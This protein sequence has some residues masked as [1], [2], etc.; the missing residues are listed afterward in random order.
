MIGWYV[1]HHGHGHLARLQAVAAHLRTPVAGLS[2]L[3]A[4]AGWEGPWLRLERDD[5]AVA[6]DADLTALDVTCNGVLHWAPLHDDGLADRTAQVASWLAT[7]RPS[8]VVVDVSVEVSVL[9]RLAGV[10]V[11]VV[12]MPG[13]RRDRAHRLAYDLADALLAPWPAGTHDAGWPEHWRRKLWAVGGITR[14]DASAAHRDGVAPAPDGMRA[15]DADGPRR[16]LVLWGAGGTDVGA[17]QL[18]AARAVTP[19]WTWVER[20]PLNPSPDLAADLAEAD[21]VVTH[22]GQNAVADV[23]ALRRPAVVVAQQRP[24][25]EQVATAEAVERLHAAVGL[26]A[27]PGDATRWPAILRRALELGGHGWSGWSAGGG[28]AEAA[29][30]LDALATRA[31]P[32]GR[33]PVGAGRGR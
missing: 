30:R 14:L 33:T 2:S 22:A 3:P 17:P 13:Q 26:S 5:A 9:T 11:V 15:R 25:G 18:D 20:S 28:A 8:L 32:P 4:P 24:F 12:A 29:A 21:V 16:V 1:H 10:P 19:G 6:A 7:A 27:W 23:A 31:A